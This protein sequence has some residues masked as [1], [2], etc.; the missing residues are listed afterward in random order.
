VTAEDRRLFER[1][2]RRLS[3]QGGLSIRGSAL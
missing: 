2:E 1:I 3:E